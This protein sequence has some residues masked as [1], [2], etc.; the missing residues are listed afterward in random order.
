MTLALWD[1]TL[2]NLVEVYQ[3]FR[4]IYCLHLQCLLAGL[5]FDLNIVTVHSSETL[6]NFYQTTQCQI[7]RI[8]LCSEIV[9]LGLCKRIIFHIVRICRRSPFFV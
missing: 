8:L 6:V 3:H 5:F 9:F 4:G 2:C 7:H 1:V